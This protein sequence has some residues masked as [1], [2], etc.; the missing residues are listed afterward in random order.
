GGIGRALFHDGGKGK[1][2]IL[3]RDLPP[4]IVEV[5]PLVHVKLPGATPIQDFPALCQHGTHATS[6]E[7]STQQVFQHGFE[8]NVFGSHIL[9]RQPALV[10]TGGYPHAH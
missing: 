3:G 9:V 6:F 7:V 8:H 4:A 5:D 10:A 1:L 2:D